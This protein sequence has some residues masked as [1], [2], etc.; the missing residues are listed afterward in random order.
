MNT[1]IGKTLYRTSD[2][3]PF[4]YL[5]DYNPLSVKNNCVKIKKHLQKN[6]EENNPIV[7]IGTITNIEYFV[8]YKLCK[9]QS[10]NYNGYLRPDQIYF[11]LVTDKKYF[12][13]ANSIEARNNQLCFCGCTYTEKEIATGWGGFNR[14]FTKVHVNK[15]DYTVNYDG[16]GGYIAEAVAVIPCFNQA[17]EE[18]WNKTING[19]SKEHWLIPNLVRDKQIFLDYE[20]QAFAAINNAIKE[21]FILLQNMQEAFLDELDSVEKSSANMIY[22]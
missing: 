9:D 3:S 13:F 17:Y 21:K 11:L 6:S 22:M 7:S 14:H 4:V 15:C 10:I 1:L 16:I 2:T 8:K 18:R 19:P 5:D 12:Y 20:D